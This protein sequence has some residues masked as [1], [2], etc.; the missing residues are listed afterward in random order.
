MAAGP[1]FA[2]AAPGT[3]PPGPGED[4]R[5][6]GARETPGP[7]HAR[8]AGRAWP[9]AASSALYDIVS[10]PFRPSRILG[11]SRLA[12]YLEIEDPHEA[13][14]IALLARDAVRLPNGL[15]LVDTQSVGPFAD[16][17]EAT[18]VRIGRCSA[19]FDG[20][21]GPRTVRAGRW[22]RPPLPRTARPDR[23]AAAAAELDRALR[24]AAG[25][26]PAA[27]ADPLDADLARPDAAEEACRRLVGLGPGLTPSGDDL[28][29]GYLLAARHLGAPAAA[30]AL[31]AAV[32]RAAP[33]TTALSAD[34]LRH[35]A[36]GRA[37]PQAVG[38]LDALSGRAPLAPAL[39]ALRGIGHT[40]GT[41]LALGLSAGARAAL[42]SAGT[43]D[44]GSSP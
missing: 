30:D 21:T 6:D 44:T 23:L 37:C 7:E 10:G 3:G 38:V 15:V 27:A 39:R 1:P 16:V 40:S 9:A 41:D 20:P 34:L 43:H 14:V 4:A 13:T 17:A 42:R 5:A 29:C 32:R 36:A 19:V 25:G 33:A 26:L 35:A 22:W 28:L 12:V 24:G 11:V 18:S 8:S 31:A 2:V